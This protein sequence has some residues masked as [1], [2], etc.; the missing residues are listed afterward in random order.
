[1]TTTAPKTTVPPVDANGE[2]TDANAILKRFRKQLKGLPLD[3]QRW[4][5]GSLAAGLDANE[6]KGG[7]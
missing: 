7:E 5:V 3:W 1:M 4:V 6:Q 2:T